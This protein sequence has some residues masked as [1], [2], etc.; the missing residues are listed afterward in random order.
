MVC[1]RFASTSFN[2][3]QKKICGCSVVSIET[4]NNQ[5]PNDKDDAKVSYQIF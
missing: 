3:I 5:K 4:I 2:N 1:F